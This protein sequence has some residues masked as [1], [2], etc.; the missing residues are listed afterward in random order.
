MNT[1]RDW[2]KCVNSDWNGECAEQGYVFP[3]KSPSKINS[4]KKF[5]PYSAD[6][7]HNWQKIP[8]YQC[9]DTDLTMYPDELWNIEK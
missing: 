8:G 1:K 6:G 3:G 9:K 4:I 2:Y 7:H 5:C